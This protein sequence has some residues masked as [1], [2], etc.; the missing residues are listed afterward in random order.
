MKA[1]LG[2]V[3]FGIGF[4]AVVL[5]AGIAFYVAPSAARLPYDLKLCTPEVTEDCLKPSIAEAKNARF[6]YTEGGSNPVV[7][8]ETGT[9]QSTTE[10]KPLVDTTSEELKSGKI[11]ENTVIWSAYGTV[12]WAE[13]DKVVSAYEARLAIDRKTAAAVE[14]YGQ[15]LD[16]VAKG[17]G[18]PPQAAEDVS[19]T[20][21][22]Y[23]F[24]FGTEQ[25]TY[26][27]FDRDL[28]KAL[29]IEF[30]GVEDIQGLETYKFEQV[31]AETPLNFSDERIKSLLGAFAT[32]DATSAQVTY[33]NTRTIWVEP[34]SGT[35]VKVQE[36]QRKK[37]VP[38]VGQPTDL[39]E[40]VFAYTDETVD[41]SVES[42]SA[43]KSQVLLISRY[44][45]IGAAVL[46]S[47]L[48][49]VGLWMVSTSRKPAPAKH[50]VAGK[51]EEVVEQTASVGPVKDDGSTTS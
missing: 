15:E 39:L 44:L 13:E 1:R 47:I 28:K 31:I 8:I 51:H 40:G 6:L 33:A 48:L 16:D 32:P 3:L 24:P 22:L 46:G 41:N 36:Q 43:N 35:F 38:N 19:F 21:Q 27:Y 34:V 2:A 5:A 12:I 49:I 9:L 26:Q 50:A 20:G 25:K 18:F 10:I 30:K 14:W 11:D 17:E 29:P 23:K 7:K 4:F 45:P 42:A 37:L